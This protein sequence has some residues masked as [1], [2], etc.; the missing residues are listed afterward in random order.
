MKTKLLVAAVAVASASVSTA[1]AY[2]GGSSSEQGSLLIFP[3]VQ[4]GDTA[5]G[6]SDTLISIVNNS[7]TAV[8]L[9]CY[10]ATSKSAAYPGSN[11]G[12]AD[13]LDA[14]RSTYYQGF[15]VNVTKNDPVSFWAGNIEQLANTAP[16]LFI[17]HLT[18]IESTPIFNIWEN[19]K[20]DVHA[21]ELKCWAVN[22]AATKEIKHNYLS[23]KATVYQIGQPTSNPNDGGLPAIGELVEPGQAYEYNAWAFKANAI[24]T[25]P[26]VLKLNGKEY[27][28][29]PSMLLGQFMPV[30]NP[31]TANPLL[32]VTANTQISVASCWEDL[33]QD[34]KSHVTKLTYTTWNANEVKIGSGHDCMGVWYE[35]DLKTFPTFLYKNASRTDSAYFRI[36]PVAS[37]IC[38]T[39]N[40][41]ALPAASND[42]TAFG[43]VGV[44]VDSVYSPAYLNQPAGFK[45]Q[46]GSNL[47]GIT[48]EDTESYKTRPD[49]ILWD[50]D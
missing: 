10:Y 14:I 35:E 22:N 2:T 32:R 46:S 6:G 50:R 31:I 5:G 45:F 30:D 4:A 20:Y 39:V 21:G 33:R 24:D 40:H 44:Q 15:T 37:P 13:V 28:Q 49:S 42:V 8:T 27:D 1:Y 43:I 48:D 19:G 47:I 38:N 23:G 3:R 18:S 9:Q 26:G 16:G 36:K 41:P 34:S 25:L 7:A 29:C 12:K 17:N 11:Q